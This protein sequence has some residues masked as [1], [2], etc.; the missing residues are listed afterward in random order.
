MDKWKCTICGNI[1]EP[2]KGDPDNNVKAGT[3]FEELPD[4]WLCPVCSSLKEVYEM[5]GD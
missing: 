3:K 1:Y 4:N 5:L 2:E